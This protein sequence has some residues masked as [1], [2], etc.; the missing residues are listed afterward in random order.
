MKKSLHQIF[1]SFFPRKWSLFSNTYFVETYWKVC[2]VV[3]GDRLNSPLRCWK[4][5]KWL[6]LRKGIGGWDVHKEGLHSTEPRVFGQWWQPQELEFHPDA[7]S[8]VGSS[9]QWVWELRYWAENAEGMQV[10]GQVPQD[11]FYSL[12]VWLLVSRET[13]LAFV[14]LWREAYKWP[15]GSYCPISPTQTIIGEIKIM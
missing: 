8:L 10:C 14:L 11:S 9:C 5:N 1:Y 4:R 6:Y 15:L 2:L 13:F 7:Q 12:C 3:H